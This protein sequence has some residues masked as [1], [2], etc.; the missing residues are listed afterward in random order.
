M[1]VWLAE[2]VASLPAASLDIIVKLYAVPESSLVSMTLWLVVR[3]LFT[4]VVELVFSVFSYLTW[5]VAGSSVIQVMTAPD[6][7]M[8]ETLTPEIVGAV[9]SVV[10]AVVVVSFPSDVVSMPAASVDTTV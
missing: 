5:L 9:L 6:S 3:F 1:N 4:G 10:A 8:L 2:D 7:V